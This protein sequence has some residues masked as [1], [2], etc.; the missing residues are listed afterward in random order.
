MAQSGEVRASD[1]GQMALPQV[2]HRWGLDGSGTV[3]WVDL[4]DAMLLVP[5]GIAGLRSELLGRAAWKAA[6]A[7]FGDPEPANH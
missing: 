7:G 1:R 2:R 6:R 5:G 4:G 3:G